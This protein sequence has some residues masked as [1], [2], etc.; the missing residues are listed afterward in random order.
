MSMSMNKAMLA[1]VALAALVTVSAFGPGEA[2][3]AFNLKALS[4]TTD[5]FG[6][7]VDVSGLGSTNICIEGSVT[8]NLSCA[9]ANKGQN[10]TSDAK[11]NT[12]ALE[13]Q[14]SQSVA[15]KNGRVTTTF[16]LPLNVSDALCEGD[17][18]NLA[19]P[20]GQDAKLVKFDATEPATFTVCTTTAAAGTPCTCAGAPTQGD[21]PATIT[22]GPTGGVPFPGKNDSCLD[23]FP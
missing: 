18:A 4:C 17:P 16:A 20:G 13:A 12:A 1:G 2:R 11:K 8:L 6:V 21:L 5:P 22:C 9:C 15:P 23:L 19:C 14:A 7:R 3:A 10:C